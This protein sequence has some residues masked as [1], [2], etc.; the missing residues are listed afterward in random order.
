MLIDLNNVTMSRVIKKKNQNHNMDL[1]DF[2]RHDLYDFRTAF[3]HVP[4]VSDIY[5]ILEGHL[6]RSNLTSL[7]C[8]C[9]IYTLRM[10]CR[11]NAKESRFDVRFLSWYLKQ[12]NA[13]AYIDS[14]KADWSKI[15]NKKN[16][17][18]ALQNELARSFIP[19]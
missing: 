12:F 5:F 14:K 19:F 11:T 15:K 6:F 10:V 2:S 8:R 7:T 16:A 18:E 3:C 9:Y 17:E 1:Y 4:N 13:A